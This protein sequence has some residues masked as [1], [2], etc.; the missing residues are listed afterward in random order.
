MKS[1]WN[2]LDR[3][4]RI[5]L[6]VATGF[7][8][9]R[10]VVASLSGFGFHQGWNEGHYALVAQGFL[11][12][13]LV[14]RY[15]DK[16]VYN[17][18]PLFPYLVSA[19]FALFGESVLAARLPSVLTTS[20]LIVATYALGREI[21]DD[22]VALFGA[23]FLA[24]LPYIQLYGGR[25]QTDA[26]MV[27]FVTA[28]LAAIIR[29]YR[30]PTNYRRWLVAGGFLFAA[31]VATKQPALLLAGVVFCWLLANLRVDR[32]TIRRTS[33]LIAASALFLLPVLVWFYLNYLAA[34]AAFVADW[35]HELFKRT[36][37]FANVHLL[38]AIAFGLGMT[39][40]V[41]AAAAVGLGVDLRDALARYRERVSDSLGPSVITWWL[42]LF[43][44]F[45]LARTPHGHQ[46]YA[47]VLAP[48]IALFAA[49]GVHVAASRLAGLRGHS[50]ESVRL[51]LVAIVLVSTICSTVILF[52][53]SGEFS[54]ANGGGTHVAA[55]AGDFLVGNVPDNATILVSNGYS[56]PIKWY[57][58]GE[59]PIERVTSYHISKLTDDRLRAIA[60][61]RS[62]PVYLIYPKPAWADRPETPLT[63]VYETPPYKYTMMSMAG[64]YVDTNSK[65]TFYLNNRRL[66]V[67]RVGQTE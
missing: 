63:R 66:V 42:V 26:T 8:L 37:L 6:G 45:V 59:F 12:H 33:L 51:A 30:R 55:D 34:P 65:F 38:V 2:A 44:A 5:V 14:P 17:V 46:Y 36:Y 29:G 57:V 39:P 60:N 15:G 48:P 35:R 7:V 32:D 64:S 43:G 19:S 61:E 40:P 58:H 54:A 25:V 20:G 16:F 18:P 23:I 52:E 13:P 56:P 31:A 50:R 49:R 4:T 62:G 10:T 24:T 67:Y 27:F 1:R 3:E 21:Y 28:S 22:R 47:V 9:F 53:L 11:E 41:L